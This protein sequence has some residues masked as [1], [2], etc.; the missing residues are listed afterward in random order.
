MRVF[1]ALA[2]FAFSA[3]PAAARVE[4]FVD[5]SAQR[6]T[7]VKNGGEKAVWKISSGRNGYETPTGRFEVQ[8]MD[9]DHYSDEYDQAPMPWSIFFYRGLAIH[10]T[11]EGGLGRP[12]SHG[13]VRLSIPHARELYDLV[14]KYG[15]TIEISGIAGRGGGIAGGGALIEDLDSRAHSGKRRARRAAKPDIDNFDRLYGY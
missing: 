8:R 2:A 3:G 13:C 6:M 11:F 5:L 12:R 4:I 10:G 9:A 15:A 1:L 14:E 7:V